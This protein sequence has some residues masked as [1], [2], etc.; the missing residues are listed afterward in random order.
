[1]YSP[2]S[3]S[4]LLSDDDQDFINQWFTH[5]D[6][7]FNNPED[8]AARLTRLKRSHKRRTPNRRLPGNCDGLLRILTEIASLPTHR[9]RIDAANIVSQV[10][11][12]LKSGA[13]ETLVPDPRRFPRPAPGGAISQSA[14][15]PLPA[16]V[17]DLPPDRAPGAPIPDVSARRTLPRYTSGIAALPTENQGLVDSTARWLPE[18]DDFVTAMQNLRI[19]RADD[20]GL[21]VLLLIDHPLEVVMDFPETIALITA[22]VPQV[23]PTLQT[24]A[25][26]RLTIYDTRLGAPTRRGALPQDHYI[27]KLF[28]LFRTRL[29]EPSVAAKYAIINRSHPSRYGPGSADNIADEP[30]ATVNEGMC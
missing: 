2:P 28:E 8:L 16:V 7:S 22:P 1:M 30:P 9:H 11:A 3:P 10:N 24:A 6:F 25:R 4:G 13:V 17:G 20:P 5:Y 27:Y 23:D 15:D 21:H 18:T 14:N 26:G 29:L 19:M 12:R